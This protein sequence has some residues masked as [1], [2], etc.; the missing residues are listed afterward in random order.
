[1]ILALRTDNL[2]LALP[3][4]PAEA[5]RALLHL[6][7]PVTALDLSPD[8]TRLAIGLGTQGVRILDLGR[9]GFLA[10]LSRRP[11]ATAP[12]PEALPPPSEP[13]GD[14]ALLGAFGSVDAA[15]AA[16]PKGTGRAF[17]ILELE[18]GG[19]VLVESLPGPATAL[20]RA[21]ALARVRA[22]VPQATLHWLSELCPG[23]AEPAPR[24]R[25]APAPNPLTLE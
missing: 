23:A 17:S 6:P 21:N 15:L 11:F 22:D 25:C 12:A 10:W 20:S 4:D 14:I 7:G 18:G 5:A 1:M 2:L 13:W 3:R 19:T 9:L 16:R 8:G 24:M